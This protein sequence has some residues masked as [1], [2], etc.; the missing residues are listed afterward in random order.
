MSRENPIQALIFDIG[1]VIVRV[2]FERAVEALA[3]N[4][5]IFPSHVRATIGGHARLRDFQEGRITELAWYKWLSAELG[6]SLDFE[7]FCDVWNSALDNEP[8]LGEDL[9]ARLAAGSRL[10]LLSNTDPIHAAHL[11]THFTFPRHFPAR[12][13]SFAAGASKPSPAIYRHAIAQA[14]VEPHSILYVD[15]APEYAEAGRR[16]GMQAH[17]FEN[18]AALLA[19]LRA[20]KL[21]P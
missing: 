2:H 19:E 8:I 15:D 16:A 21:L 18:P 3:S 4:A 1:Q 20:R 11:E 12:V 9:F 6:L 7:G 14:G 13:Y 5:G 10:V 17:R